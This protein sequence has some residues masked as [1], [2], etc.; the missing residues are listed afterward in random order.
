M[1]YV[2]RFHFILRKIKKCALLEELDIQGPSIV[3]VSSWIEVL[4]HD[5]FKPRYISS[6]YFFDYVH[7]EKTKNTHKNQLLKNTF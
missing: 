4:I 1:V 2:L 5:L 6:R 3:K 7:L